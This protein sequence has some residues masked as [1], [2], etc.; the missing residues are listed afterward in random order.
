[1]EPFDQDDDG[2]GEENIVPAARVGGIAQTDDF[3]DGVGFMVGYIHLLL[4]P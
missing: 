4:R 1:M 2:I 3:T